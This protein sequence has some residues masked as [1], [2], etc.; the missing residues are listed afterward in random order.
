MKD[1][2]LAENNTTEIYGKSYGIE[3]AVAVPPDPTTEDF[4]RSVLV[5]YQVAGFVNPVDIIL[6]GKKLTFNDGFIDCEAIHE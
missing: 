2:L 1:Y 6:N 5:A 3:W 4:F